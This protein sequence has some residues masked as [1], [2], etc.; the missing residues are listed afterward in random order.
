MDTAL[1][2]A[3]FLHYAAALQLLGLA[4]FEAFMVP[5]VLG[6]WLRGP[7]RWIARASAWTLLVSVIAW[8]ML[9]AGTMGEGWADAANTD[10]IITVLAS[11]A[12]GH[13]WTVRLVLVAL[14]LVTVMTMDYSRRRTWGGLALLAALTL[15]SLGLVGHATMD[16]GMMG[17]VNEGSQMLHLLAS[18]FWVGSLLPLAFCLRPSA[19]PKQLDGIETTLHRFSGLGH[20]AVALV[21]G[22]GVINGWF[23]VGP[24][25][26]LT[27][28]YDI[29]LLI[30]IGLV[31]AMVGIAVIN[32]YVFM[33]KIAHDQAGVRQLRAGTVAEIVICFGVIAFVSVLGVLSP[34]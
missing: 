9:Q 20:I 31:A 11:T 27:S 5:P 33:P 2:A 4:V 23:I 6:Q 15:G 19:G 12:F 28:T 13:V 32:R 16:T 34:A 7:S 14:V 3:R 8:L 26:D 18:G 25:P 22:T 10:V 29:L 1:Y 24:R 30:K 17:L 21:V